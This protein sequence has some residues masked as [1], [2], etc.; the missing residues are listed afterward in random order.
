MSEYIGK[1]VCYDQMDG[2]ACWGK[3]KDEAVVNT[4]NGEKSVFIL[5]DRYVRYVVGRNDKYLRRFY[6][7]PSQQP[8]MYKNM[9]RTSQGIQDICDDKTYKIKK[10]YGDSTLRIESI[11][12]ENDI[13]DL[14]DIL[15]VVNE[16][17]LFEALLKSFENDNVINGKTAL[18]I[19]L[20]ALLETN[21]NE[22]TK[23]KI[24][25]HLNKR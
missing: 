9:Q 10:V 11:D 15:S 2:G 14:E 16:E 7:D 25:N 22:T 6:P 18:E 21:L 4:M 12:L 5:T 8:T 13:V 23:N 19:G 20:Y 1:Y 17:E 24:K 3:I